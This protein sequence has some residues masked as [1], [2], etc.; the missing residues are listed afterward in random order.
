MTWIQGY[1]PKWVLDK[2]EA[3]NFIGVWSRQWVGKTIERTFVGWYESNDSWYEDLPIILIIGGEQIEICWQKFDSLSITKNQINVDNC[4]SYD[5]KIP[6]RE[7]ALSALSGAIGKRILSVK[8]GM[9]FMTL[10]EKVIPMINSVDFE[11]ENGFLSIFNA[12]DENGVSN[13]PAGV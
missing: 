5:E 8:L 10:E 2:V 4:I 3:E 12:L 13:V 7:N 11:L 6:Y 1:N 9:S